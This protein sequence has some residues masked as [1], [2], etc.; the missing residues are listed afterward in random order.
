MRI[1]R[2]M[3]TLVVGFLACAIVSPGAVT[4]VI[5]FGGNSPR[6]D[7]DANVVTNDLVTPTEYS[8]S[9]GVDAFGLDRYQNTDIS[10]LVITVTYAETN[11]Y[12]MDFD[13]PWLG[14]QS[15]AVN[16][17]SNDGRLDADEV[18]KFTVSVSDPDNKLLSLK[19]KEI[20]TWWN[21]GAT[22]TM[23]FSDGTSSFSMTFTENGA[24]T[25]FDSTGLTQLST[26]NVNTWQLLVSV[27]DS[28]G[29]TEAAMGSLVLEYVADTD[30][31]AL[32][33][34]T[35]LTATALD[36]S[37]LLDWDD[38]PALD[39]GSYNVYRSTS[40]G[41]YGA[42][43]T[44]VTGSAYADNTVSN[45]TTYY[46]V[47]TT[48]DNRPAANES[49]V[50]AEISATPEVAGLPSEP[51]LFGSDFDGL[52][53]FIQ[54]TINTNV[55]SW[56]TET[57][58]VRYTADDTGYQNF[59]FLRQFALD[60]SPGQSYTITAS[61]IW[62]T[63]A[64][65][66][67][68]I[69][70]YMFG[71]YADLGVSPE[72]QEQYALGFVYNADNN[73]LRAVEGIDE[74]KIYD[75]TKNGTP[76]APTSG[77]IIDYSL[78]FE[79]NIDFVLDTATGTNMVYVECIMTDNDGV[80][81][82]NSITPGIDSDYS[83]VAEEWTGD[84]FGFVGRGQNDRD[85]SGDE[86]YVANLTSFSITNTTPVVNPLDD[87]EQWA[88]ENGIGDVGTETNDYD[89][90]G[91]A[92]LYEYGVGGSP[93]NALDQGTAPVFTKAGDS[94]IYVHP[95]RSDT[96]ILTYTVETTTNLVSGVWTNTGYAVGGTLPGSP[97]NMVTNTVT[98]VEDEKFI[99][100]K[101]EKQ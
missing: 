76:A 85:D 5:P 21:T 63:Y 74:D 32:D 64:D 86:I 89:F 6:I 48:V 67:N 39:V 12:P 58:S 78:T 13:P 83:G 57:N 75:V 71:D 98:T 92:N 52:G 7:W 28:L 11:G 14:A 22:E 36:G 26:N 69:G 61:L 73:L 4:N 51:I 44:N 91:V 53:G 10:N 55:E 88:S 97:L 56:S 25:N 62:N 43:L 29:V 37:V 84:W 8:V 35:N 42:A 27:D 17:L 96:D 34:P 1:K 46:Y 59:S 41:S 3:L 54:S 30:Y 9:A 20:S 60:R 82:T 95:E 81:T 49:A 31:V 19:V 33:A 77:D 50:S 79:A 45:G 47:V 99:R 65:D 2:K 100:L 93:T 40:S 16:P 87:Y 90:D 101:I 23:V 68:R 70:I 18:L 38:N 66:N 72:H 24:V 80:K 94:F 15:S